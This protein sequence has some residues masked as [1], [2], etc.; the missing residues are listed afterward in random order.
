LS[1]QLVYEISNLS[2]N[3]TDS[4]RDRRTDDMRSQDRAF[5]YSASRGKN[6]KAVMTYFPLKK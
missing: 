6:V 4:Q 5:H 2:T 1:L 3:V